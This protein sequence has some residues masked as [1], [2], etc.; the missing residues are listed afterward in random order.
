VKRTYTFLIAILAVAAVSAPL[1][2][3]QGCVVAR[4]NGEIGG[5]ESEGGYITPGE[6]DV[7]IGYRHQFSFEHYIG[8]QVE[9]NTAGLSRTQLGTQVENKINL[10]NLS[11][12]YQI[13]PRFSVTA[14]VPILTASRHSNNTNTF[15]L[16]DGIGDTSFLVSGW[17]WNPKENTKGN[18]QLGFGLQIPTGNDDVV[19]NLNGKLTTDDYSVQPG[20]G[21]YGIIMQWSSFKNIQKFGQI[22]F[23]GSY[24]ATPQV[25]NGILRSATAANQPLTEYNSISDQYLLETGVAVPVRKVRGLTLTF[26]PRWEGVP[27]HDLIGDSIGFRRPGYALSIEPGAQ[28]YFHGNVLTVS[29]AKAMYRNRTVSETD[30]LLGTH[31]DAAFANYVWLASYSF[32]FNPFHKNMSGH[33][34]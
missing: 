24:L 4:S 11:L 6:F 13:S 33:H 14:N 30:S 8:D 7:N 20:S 31:G 34:T 19:T 29:V 5:P 23:N 26:G 21:G 9:R 15:Q 22:Y 17:L 3:A 12:T 25:T 16:A 32:R 1:A 18:I 27:A 10:E 28:F 2:H